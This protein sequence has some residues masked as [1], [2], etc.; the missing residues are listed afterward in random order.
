[1]ND[2]GIPAAAITLEDAKMFERMQN[3]N[4]DIVIELYMEVSSLKLVHA[5]TPAVILLSHE[6]P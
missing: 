3:R 2:A 5:R 1:M 6:E 4:Q